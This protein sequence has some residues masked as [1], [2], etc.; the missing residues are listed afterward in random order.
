MT[1]VKLLEALKTRTEAAIEELFMPI[2]PTKGEPA[3]EIRI[4]AVYIARLPDEKASNK[5]APYV[6]HTIANTSYTQQPGI[7]LWGWPTC[8]RCSACIPQMSRKAVCSSST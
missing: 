8:G 6:L 5:Y 2:K 4:P 1:S 3:P 7:C